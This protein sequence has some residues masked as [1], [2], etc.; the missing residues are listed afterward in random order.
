VSGWFTIV[1]KRSIRIKAK[2]VLKQARPTANSSQNVLV[3]VGSNEVSR[4]GDPTETIQKSRLALQDALRVEVVMSRLYHTPAFPAGAGPDF[5]NGV[6]SLRTSRD[7]AELL[8][9]LHAL[10]NAAGRVREQRWGPRTLDLDLLAYGDV[11]A[12]NL[13]V[14]TDWH[15]LDPDQQTEVAPDQLILPHPR[16]QD[17]AFVLVPLSDVAP[18]WVHPVLDLSVRDLLDAMPGEELADVVPLL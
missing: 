18:T 9:L 3:S 16:L 17:R 13:D 8:E 14:W 12:P 10:E 7:P 5:V 4:W 11:V 2:P 1:P 15:D 6:F